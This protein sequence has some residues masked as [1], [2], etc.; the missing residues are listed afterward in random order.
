M[1]HGLG[2]MLDAVS[3]LGTS[4]PRIR[5]FV[6][7]DGAEIADLRVRAASLGLSNVVFMGLLPRKDIPA[8]MAGTDLVLVTLKPSETFKT[9]LPSK[10]F[11]AMAA[12]K[13]I[14]LAVDG[15]A[16]QTLER[17]QCGVWVAPGDARALANAVAKLARSADLRAR[18][19][20]S[21]GDYVAREFNRALWAARYLRILS[22][23]SET[24]VTAPGRSLGEGAP[25]HARRLS[26]MRRANT[27][28]T[29]PG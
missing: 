19:G 14:V 18:L 11:E 9:V 7:G 21:G 22:D 10:M 12:R 6:V 5:F 13:P 20:N 23:V 8:I 26:V 28:I 1:A 29:P 24:K 2:T 25:S 15:E 16:K 27:S 3:L 17:A 4:D